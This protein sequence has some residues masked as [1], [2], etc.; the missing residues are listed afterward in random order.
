MTA[1]ATLTAI[2]LLTLTLAACG[3]DQ[4]PPAEG[5]MSKMEGEKMEAADAMATDKMGA[6]DAMATDKMEATDP[7]ASDAMGAPDAMAADKMG[8]DAMGAMPE[9]K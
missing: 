5:A 6:S 2:A 9:K 4:T 7:M 1:R 3:Q 8:A